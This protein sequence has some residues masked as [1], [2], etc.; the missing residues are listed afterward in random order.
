[1]LKRNCR[2]RTFTPR[3]AP[4]AV[5]ASS[6]SRVFPDRSRRTFFE[7]RFGDMHGFDIDQRS[8]TTMN[9]CR[10]SSVSDYVKKDARGELTRAR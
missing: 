9:V 7:F 4:P 2:R 1:M 10:E 6:A 5:A 8:A 3:A